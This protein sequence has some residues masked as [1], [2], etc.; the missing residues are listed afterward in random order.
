MVLVHVML[1][2]IEFE[3]ILASVVG[4]L[5]YDGNLLEYLLF[6]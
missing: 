6:I 3:S 2:D 4:V 1:R 5:I